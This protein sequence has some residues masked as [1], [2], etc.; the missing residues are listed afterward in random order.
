MTI[1]EVPDEDDHDYNIHGDTYTDSESADATSGPDEP[2]EPEGASKRKRSRRHKKSKGHKRQKKNGSDGHN[3]DLEVEVMDIESPILFVR[4]DKSKDV[5]HFFS[6][7]Y[8]DS[9]KRMCNC[10]KCRCV[11]YATLF[12]SY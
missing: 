5:D 4:R 2:Q 11:V 7:A 3:S 12:Y 6:P 10:R 1:T 9:G 8:T